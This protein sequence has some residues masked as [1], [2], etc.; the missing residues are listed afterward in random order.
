MKAKVPDAAFEELDPRTRKVTE[1][2][3]AIT[4]ILKRGD[5]L[6][7]QRAAAA[8]KTEAAALAG[9]YRAAVEAWEAAHPKGRGRAPAKPAAK[10]TAKPP[11]RKR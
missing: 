10:A 7:A 5:L 3:E 9:Q 4:A 6:E 8:V 11:A 2:L 1:D